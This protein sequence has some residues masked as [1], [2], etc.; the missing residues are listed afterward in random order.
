[1]NVNAKYVLGALLLCLPYLYCTAEETGLYTRWPQ[2]PRTNADYFPLGVWLQNPDD[3]VSWKNAGI[4]LYLGLWQGPTAEQLDTLQNADMQV[5]AEQNETSLQYCT[6]KLSNGNPLIIGYLQPDEPDNCQ[7]CPGGWCK[8]IP[9]SVIQQQY[10]D[11]KKNDPNRPILLGLSQGIACDSMVWVG[12]GGYIVPERDYPAYIA[13]SDITTFDIYPMDCGQSATCGQAWRVPL[14]IDRLYQFSPPGHIVWNTME[15]SDIS[16]NG[17]QA[18]TQEVR[19][20]AWMSIIH[21][22][23]GLIFFIH[24]KTSLSNFDSRA[25]LRPENANRLAAFTQMNREIRQLAPVINSPVVEGLVNM[26]SVDNSSPVDFAVHFYEG[27]TYVFAAGMRQE[28]TTKRFSLPHYPDTVVDV[29]GE[30][31]QIQLTNT[32]FTDTFHGYQS[33]LYKIYAAIP[34]GDF[35]ADNRV[36]LLDI[37]ILS[38]SWQCRSDLPQWNW[39]CDIAEPKDNYIDLAD[40]A[41]MMNSWLI[42]N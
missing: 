22:S 31:R 29:I 10:A 25:M 38:Q 24:G 33:H 5:I 6:A 18:T 23:K 1:M 4:N 20:E 37:S 2:G 8:P 13:G 16:A 41:V 32:A 26:E 14:G 30:E 21:G 3:A 40:L 27:M 19:A 42:Y 39:K 34:A 17:I 36:D 15:T 11:W 9:T 7:A 12:Q 28:T 35:N